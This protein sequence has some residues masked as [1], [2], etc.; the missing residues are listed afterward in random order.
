MHFVVAH[1]KHSEVGGLQGSHAQKLLRCEMRQSMIV[2]RL[3]RETMSIPIK[4][5]VVVEK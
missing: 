4:I 5:L 1:K 3:T 2:S